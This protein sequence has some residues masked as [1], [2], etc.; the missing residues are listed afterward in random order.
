VNSSA[1]QG[2]WQF[3]KDYHGMSLGPSRG[4]AMVLKGTFS[5]S[6]TPKGGKKITD[7]YQIEITIPAA[8]PRVLPSAKENGE[9]IPRNGKYHVN[10]DKTLCLGSPLRLLHK[11][12]I[13]PTL[14]GFA[15]NCLVP[16]LYAVSNKLQNGEEFPFGE[17]AHGEK[18]IIEDYL[19]IFRFK[20]RS[21]V[22]NALIL[23]GTKRRIA[24]KQP[25]PCECGRRLG[26]CPFHRTLNDYRKMTSRSWFKTHQ[27]NLGAGM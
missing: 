11:I 4:A 13:N 19:G 9:K 10:S 26:G 15:E 21:Q 7:S 14:V 18:G 23:L 6:A 22:N 2:V 3:L 24:N 12:A 17:L 27:N 5:F 16:Y 25:C 1:V 20:T 8:F